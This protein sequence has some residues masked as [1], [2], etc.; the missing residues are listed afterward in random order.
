MA[1]PKKDTEALTVRLS[2]ELIDAIDDR[3]RVEPDLPTRP[4]MIRRA[5]LQWL[6][7]TGESRG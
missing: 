5:L 7:L 3:R 6:E 2:R 1:P 4:E